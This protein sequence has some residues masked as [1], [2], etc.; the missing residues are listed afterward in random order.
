M[1][2]TLWIKEYK[3]Q[4]CK[5]KTTFVTSGDI[6]VFC[7]C[8][9]EFNNDDWISVQAVAFLEADIIKVISNKEEN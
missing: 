7:Q 2:A 6:D 5:T 1:K 8:G 4:E 9:H 3:C